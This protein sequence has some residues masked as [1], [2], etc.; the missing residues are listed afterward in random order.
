MHPSTSQTHLPPLPGEAEP[1]DLEVEVEE[2]RL[3]IPTDLHKQRLDRALV[4]LMP[5]L[6]LLLMP[7]V[8]N[9]PMEVLP[10]MLM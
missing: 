7:L 3:E 8:F 9:M 5:M 1:D 10:L 2:R 6:M 4:Q